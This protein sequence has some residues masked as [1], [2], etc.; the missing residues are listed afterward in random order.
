MSD[1]DSLSSGASAIAALLR[2]ASAA[3]H[4]PSRA[5]GPCNATLPPRDEPEFAII[6]SAGS[7]RLVRHTWGSCSERRLE[8][9]SDV[10]HSARRR[11]VLLHGLGVP[12]TEPLDRTCRLAR[13]TR[14]LTR[15]AARSRARD[16]GPLGVGAR[17]PQ[18]ASAPAAVLRLLR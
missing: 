16:L 7:T 12:D 5:H 9:P 17:R 14:R 3:D 15:C 18:R 10:L 2:R 8:S 4:K 6:A 13:G 11:A 1:S